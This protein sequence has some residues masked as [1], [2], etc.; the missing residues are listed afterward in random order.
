MVL[1]RRYAFLARPEGSEES[2]PKPDGV[3]PYLQGLFTGWSPEVIDI[4]QATQEHEIEQR[5]LFD[6]A[7][8]EHIGH[9]GPCLM[10]MSGEQNSIG[11]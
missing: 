7:R 9:V 8:V 5:D 2:E 10:G 6:R 1:L 11:L 3:S 4:L